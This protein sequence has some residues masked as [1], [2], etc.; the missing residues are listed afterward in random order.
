MMQYENT[1]QLIKVKESDLPLQCPLP[2]MI[3]WNSHPRVFLQITEAPNHE[4]VCPYCSTKYQLE[5]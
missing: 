3:K 2:D 5:K 1:A 4:I